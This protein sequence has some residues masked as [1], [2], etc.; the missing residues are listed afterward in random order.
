MEERS[1]GWVGRIRV[2]RVLD[3]LGM[4]ETD[5]HAKEIGSKVSSK[6]KWNRFIGLSEK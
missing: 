4:C 3:R 5:I 6:G 1:D 2:T